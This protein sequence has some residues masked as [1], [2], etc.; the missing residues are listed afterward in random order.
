[1]MIEGYE[2]VD[3]LGEG[4]MGLVYLAEHREL[5][6]RAVVKVIAPELARKPGIVDRF[7]AEAQAAGC[8]KHPGIV[9]VWNIG[10]LPSGSLYILMEHLE[11]ETVARRLKRVGRL[12]ENVAV[13]LVLQM[14]R[15]LGAAHDQGIVHRDLKPDNIFV[16]P[17]PEVNGGERA[18]ILDFGIAKLVEEQSPHCT[19]MGAQI[20]TPIYMPPEQFD[21]AASVDHRADLYALGVVF[22]EMLCGHPPFTARSYALYA[23]AHKREA[24]PPVDKINPEVSPAVAQVVAKLLEKSRE[25]RPQSASELAMLLAQA[26]GQRRHTDQVAVQT[27]NPAPEVAARDSAL[28]GPMPAGSPAVVEPLSG[29][30]TN[31]SLERSAFGT[32]SGPTATQSLGLAGRLDPSGVYRLSPDSE[33]FEESRALSPA[34]NRPRRRLHL[35]R[36]HVI[37]G[38]I[39]CLLAAI[40]FVAEDRYWKPHPRAS[41]KEAPLPPPRIDADTVEAIRLN[42]AP[43]AVNLLYE[44][45]DEPSLSIKAAEALYELGMP[46]AVK[47][48][49]VIL[50]DQGGQKR[51]ELAAYLVAMGDDSAVH[52]LEQSLEDSPHVRQRAAWGLARGGHCDKAR[53]V[54]ERVFNQPGWPGRDTWLRAAHGLLSCGDAAARTALIKELNDPEKTRALDAAEILAG[55]EDQV[56]LEWLQRRVEDEDFAF[57]GEAAL[58]LAGLDDS[59]AL[60][61]VPDGLA[62]Q[63]PLDRQ[64]AIATAARLAKRGGADYFHEIATMARD[65]RNHK[66]QVTAQVALRQLETAKD[67]LPQE[68][69]RSEGGNRSAKIDP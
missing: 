16:V 3:K 37:G 10:Q 63:E 30:S 60:R 61:F 2:V 41:H 19:V 49:Q 47:P 34:W 55:E 54:L 56:A 23:D 48:V 62:S 50:D 53:P 43:Q 68:V 31:D 46:D 11:G 66:V 24:P 4:G 9:D 39:L 27:P 1:M 20:G 14:A 28:P 51:V 18:K 29:S 52:I 8:I 65:H 6:R 42:R 13:S 15:A 33:L 58:I 5:G 38:V 25:C 21:D 57:R 44:A 12:S 64:L 32:G 26:S 17:D 45:L 22:F 67:R 69:E 35:S 40:A 59:T 7:R 36:R